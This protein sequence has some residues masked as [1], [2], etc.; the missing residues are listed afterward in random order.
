MPTEPNQQL[1]AGEASQFHLIHLLGVITAFAILSAIFAPALRALSSEQAT[2]AM[3]LA[4]IQLVFLSVAYGLGVLR[5]RTAMQGSGARLGQ[6]F[7]FS[8]VV[9]KGIS[10]FMIGGMLFVCLAILRFLL[11]SIPSHD[12]NQYVAGYLIVMIYRNFLLTAFSVPF[13]LHIHWKRHLGVIEFFQ[14]GIALT[15]FSFIPWESIQVQ[16]DPSKSNGLQLTVTTQRKYKTTHNVKTLVSDEL[17]T[18][19]LQHHGEQQKTD[20]EV[21]VAT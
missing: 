9:Q 4:G 19:L 5:R 6:S 11:W 13:L 14:N 21:G 16:P 17:H 12:T 8:P 20:A 7:A 15:P 3:S 18:Y 2:T 10:I 1:P